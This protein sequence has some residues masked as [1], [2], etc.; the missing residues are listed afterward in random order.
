M[1]INI[2]EDDIKKSEKTKSTL[3]TIKDKFS[4]VD[5]KYT[6]ADVNTFVPA[7]MEQSDRL[8][9]NAPSS[10]EVLSSAQ[11]SLES[12]KETNISGINDKYNDKLVDVDKDIE[13]QEKET[14]SNL[15]EIESLYD[16]VADKTVNKNIKKG[17]A[18][19]S[20]MTT[21][22]SDTENAK[23]KAL[24]DEKTS[25]QVKV[26]SLTSEK[27]LLQMQ[28]ETALSNFDIS[29]AVKLSEKIDSLNLEIAKQE[30]KVLKYNNALD[31]AERKFALQQE[32]LKQKYEADVTKRNNELIKL[33]NSVG[34]N[35][36]NKLKYQEKFD[37]MLNHLSSMSK[38]DALNELN[39]DT[40]YQK[41]LSSFYPLL[42][43]R[44]SNRAD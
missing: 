34:V 1:S 24:E 43:A 16:Y 31:E 5:S 40:Y 38:Q 28:K 8:T 17:L 12:Y 15:N 10:E 18:N 21:Q 7:E 30:E 39:S 22:L 36:L 4:E 9:Y 37:I 13:Q 32:V 44:V 23:V 6:I 2:T 41:Q 19:S 3:D 42:Y 11:G 29:Y 20:I 25:S 14:Q 26:D 35:G 27:Q 33:M